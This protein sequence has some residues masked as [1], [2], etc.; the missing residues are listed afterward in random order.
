MP[1]RLP[2]PRLHRRIL[3]RRLI[4]LQGWGSSYAGYYS[5]CWCYRL[6][7]FVFLFIRGQAKYLL[8]RDGKT[9]STTYDNNIIL[10]V[11]YK[12][13]LL[14]THFIFILVDRKN[15]AMQYYKQYQSLDDV[16]QRATIADME[17]LFDFQYLKHHCNIQDAHLIL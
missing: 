16:Q 8:N 12:L 10:Y 7:F 14:G 2:I 11:I 3:I 17:G 4:R 1:A 15:N 6:I 5:C 9:N 13:L